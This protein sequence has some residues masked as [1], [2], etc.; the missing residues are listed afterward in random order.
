MSGARPL[1]GFPAFVRNTAG[2]AAAEFA[3]VIP[4][5][6]LLVFG[7]L[8]MA[9][10][11]SSIVRLHYS[12]E[13]AARC[14]AVDVQGDCTE[15]AIDAYAKS[16]DPIGGLSELT[17]TYDATATCGKKVDGSGTYDV[18]TGLGSV[19]IPVTAS[20]CYPEI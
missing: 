8:N 1:C 14:L 5:L 15:G 16:L 9:L 2:A 6:L 4:L 19:S 13:R 3:L 7:T 10:A 17:F 11:M 12:T 18:F 20:A